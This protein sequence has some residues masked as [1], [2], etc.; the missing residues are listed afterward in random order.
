MGSVFVNLPPNWNLLTSKSISIHSTFSIIMGYALGGGTKT[1]VIWC[2][3]S[4]LRLE[5]NALSSCFSSQTVILFTGHLVSFFHIF[6][7]FC[8]WFHL[9]KMVPRIVL[10]CYLVFLSV[11]KLWHEL[12]R[13]YMCQIMLNELCSV[14]GY[15]AVHCEFN[16]N[17]YICIYTHTYIWKKNLNRIPH[18]TKLM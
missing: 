16:V 17:E 7:L 13:K 14:N 12:Q 4:Q 9:L 6:V 1:W 10:K 15:S 11:R 3:R 2:V 8:R 5:P 18:T